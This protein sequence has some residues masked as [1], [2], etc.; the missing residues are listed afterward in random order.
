MRGYQVIDVLKA[1]SLASLESSPSAV[2][3]A[4]C[5]Q[6][7]TSNLHSVDSLDDSIQSYS[8]DKPTQYRVNSR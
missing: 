1:I 4:C 6:V 7:H 3:D 8:T 2:A 5:P